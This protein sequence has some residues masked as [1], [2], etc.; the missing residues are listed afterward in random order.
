MAKKLI[1]ETE[2]KT[3]GIDKAV[4]KLGEL[5]QLSSKVSVQY[6]IDGKPL[7]IVIDKTLNLGQ[8]VKVLTAELRRTK[9]GTAEF[10]LL[11]S[12]LKESQDSLTRVNQKN[13]DLFATF[14]LI[15]GPIGDIFGKLNGVL[16]L[17]KTFSGFSLKDFGNQFKEL[18][19]DVIG[20]IDGFYG[21]SK[22]TEESTEK[23][24]KAIDQIEKNLV[25]EIEGLKQIN[26]EAE[27]NND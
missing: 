1:I 7:D 4:V 27:P 13:R 17:L 21:V 25:K 18:K 11:N 14:S 15:P 9:E 26:I 22:A 19:N 6:D 20:I 10:A 2:V 12:K 8:Q 5:K 24:E 3:D 23:I 16:G